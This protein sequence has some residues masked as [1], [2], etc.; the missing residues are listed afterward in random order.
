[1]TPRALLAWAVFVG[2]CVVACGDDASGA[3]GDA[4]HDAPSS[5]LSWTWTFHEPGTMIVT[6]CPD[7]VATVELAAW[8]SSVVDNGISWTRVGVGTFPCEGGE[9][10]LPLPPGSYEIVLRP[11]F[12]DRAPYA[13]TTG[14]VTVEDTLIA[15]GHSD[16]TTGR[17]FPRLFWTLTS[18]TT[19]QPGFCPMNAVVVTSLSRHD[20]APCQGGAAILPGQLPG[21]YSVEAQ[22]NQYDSNGVITQ[23]MMTTDVEVVA[24]SIINVFVAFT[25]P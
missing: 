25:V 16:I 24:D 14:V 23:S 1:M 13:E 9:G 10:S 15:T 5:N 8:Q 17:G 7:G 12:S 20:R 11:L 4:G 22:L 19:M 18:R 2:G 21:T 3:R 6:P